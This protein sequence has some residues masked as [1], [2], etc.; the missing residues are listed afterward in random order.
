MEV[1]L[2]ILL[3]ICLSYHCKGFYYDED[4]ELLKE[5]RRERERREWIKLGLMEEPTDEERLKFESKKRKKKAQMKML[6]AVHA[7]VGKE[8]GIFQI[9][10]RESKRHISRSVMM[11]A[12]LTKDFIEVNKNEDKSHLTWDQ[13]ADKCDEWM[14][15]KVSIML[16]L[17]S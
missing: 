1:I 5:E 14:V 13:V 15:R 10:K 3:F 12:T 6:N 16:N 4:A 7:R 17:I 9:D 2:I 8:D 11:T